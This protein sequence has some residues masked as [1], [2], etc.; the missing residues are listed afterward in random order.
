M[1]LFLPVFLNFSF[2]SPAL[3]SL[4]LAWSV[5]AKAGAA[6]WQGAV[7]GSLQS[8]AALLRLTVLEGKE[9]K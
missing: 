7:A 1:T 8:K 9:R 3:S 4:E 5:Q 6:H 2:L